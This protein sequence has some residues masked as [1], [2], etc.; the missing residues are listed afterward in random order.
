MGGGDW[1]MHLRVL[2][3]SDG[4]VDWETLAQAEKEDLSHQA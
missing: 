4:G 1:R 3:Y 2:S